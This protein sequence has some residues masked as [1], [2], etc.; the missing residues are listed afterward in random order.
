[1]SDRAQRLSEE[2]LTV[3]ATYNRTTRLKKHQIGGK[4]LAAFLRAIVDEC[5]T[6]TFKTSKE[7]HEIADELDNME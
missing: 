6:I 3:L 5:T 4:A 1:M 2:Y 7:I